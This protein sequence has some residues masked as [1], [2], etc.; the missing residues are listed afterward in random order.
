MGLI[1]RHLYLFIVGLVLVL[2]LITDWYYAL[3]ALL[4]CATLVNMLDKLGK[5]IVLRELVVLHGVFISLLM[6]IAGYEVYNKQNHLSRIFIKYMLVPKEEYFGFVLPAFAA[7]A[8]AICWPVRVRKQALDEGIGFQHILKELRTRLLGNRYLGLYLIITGLVISFASPYLPGALRFVWTLFYS[9]CFTGILYIHFAPGFRHKRIVLILFALFITYGAVQTGVFT[10]VAYMSLTLF[11]FFFVGKR[12]AFWKKLA[13]CM[14]GAFFLFMLQS[15]KNN[16][17]QL[18]W[19]RNYSGSKTSLFT[20]IAS[21]K[22]AHVDQMVDVNALFPI[23]TR[24]NQGYNVTMVMRYIPSRKD[25]DHG[26]RLALV[27]ASSLVPRVLWP[28]KPEAGGQESMLYFTGFKIH[29]WSTNVSP[30]GEAYGSFGV[31]GGIV[32]M[33]FLGMF[34]RWAYLRVFTLALKIPLLVLWIPVIFFQVTYSMETDT[35]QIL[36]SV[37]KSLFFVWLLY[38]LAPVWFGAVKSSH[39]WQVVNPIKKP[40]PDA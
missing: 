22:L 38:K 1:K 11:S 24:A 34:I 40:L 17:R 19:T 6:P 4:F 23:Y 15:I 16:Y 29:G 33:F 7:F 2:S 31:S 9:A 36:N 12:Q 20:D 8:L 27:A 5:G 13:V 39:K 18:T 14:V 37:F 25:F 32:F 3:A 21:E 10:V 28:D 35:L 30:V 26:E